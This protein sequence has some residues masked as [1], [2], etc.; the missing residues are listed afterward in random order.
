MEI[1][2]APIEACSLKSFVFLNYVTKL[3]LKVFL[4]FCDN[5]ETYRCLQICP[6]FIVP[7][8]VLN[9]LLLLTSWLQKNLLLSGIV[10][11]DCTHYRSA[12]ITFMLQGVVFLLR[13]SNIAFMFLEILLLNH[14][15]THHLHFILGYFFLI[16][17]NFD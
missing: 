13:K 17:T 4:L 12:Y 16:S 5:I 8:V 1:C 9:L 15:A 7:H 10:N 3:F 11:P 14:I 2:Y 6:T